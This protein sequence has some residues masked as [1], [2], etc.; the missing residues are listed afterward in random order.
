MG[1]GKKETGENTPQFIQANALTQHY[2]NQ[3][4]S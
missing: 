1:I 3:H 2:D 4:I